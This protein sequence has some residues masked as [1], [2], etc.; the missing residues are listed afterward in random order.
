MTPNELRAKR[1]AVI[2]ECRAIT[3]KYPDNSTE[4]SA[5]DRQ[6]YDRKWAE[7]NALKDQI[8]AIEANDLRRRQTAQAAEELSR[9]VDARLVPERPGSAPGYQPDAAHAGPQPVTIELKQHW[10]KTPK[11]IV[12]RPDTSAWQRHQP[13]YKAAWENYLASGRASAIL[14]SNPLEVSATLQTDLSTAGGYMV[15]PEEFVAELLMNVDDI[16]WI[17]RLARTFTTNAQTL[18]AVKRTAKMASFTWG[19]ELTDA[20]T[21]KDTTLAYGKRTLTPHYMVGEILVSRDLMRSALLPVGEFIRYEIARDSGELE[22]KGFLTGNGTQQP[23][24]VFTAT[25]DGIGTAQDVS[26]GNSTTNIG[27]DNL[28]AMKYKLKYQYREHPSLRWLWHRDAI[29]QISRLK[30]GEGHYLWQDSLAVGDPDK[31]IGIGVAE[32]EFSPN[33]FTT[34]LYVGILGAWF[35][36]WIA[37]SLEM[38]LLILVEKYAE[39]NQIAYVA[40]R[41]T[42][43]MPQIA[44][45]FVRSKLA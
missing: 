34:G 11:K 35:Y 2:G 9:P 17:R 24:G 1:A 31:I 6:L 26:T 20:S 45:A 36:Y 7:V 30:D 37:D 23:L 32:S 39:V 3:D 12:Y 40:R 43:G 27:A 29:N 41:K 42:D 19:S 44:E 16:R 13:Q 25:N 10:L 4:W 21:V 8:A 22:E 15:A 38:D 28:R 5:E 14:H 18:G 33:T